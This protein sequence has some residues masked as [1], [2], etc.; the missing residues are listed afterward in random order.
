MMAD[1]ALRFEPP[2]VAFVD[3]TKGFGFLNPAHLRKSIKRTKVS[4]DDSPSLIQRTRTPTSNHGNVDNGTSSPTRFGTTLLRRALSTTTRRSHSGNDTSTTTT[5]AAANRARDRYQ[6]KQKHRSSMVDDGGV[7]HDT[8]S[9]K[10][11]P[12]PPRPQS[13]LLMSSHQHQHQQRQVALAQ[14][15]MEE[16]EVLRR[17]A[18]AVIDRHVG[19]YM[20]VGDLVSLFSGKRSGSLWDKVKLHFR[21]SNNLGRSAS[22]SNEHAHQ[23]RVFG[24]PLDNVDWGMANND[25]GNDTTTRGD[26]IGYMMTHHP[27]M[28]ACFSKSAAIPPIMQ[29]CIL[30]LLQ[31]DLTVEGIFRKNGNIRDLRDMCNKI[32]HDE[33][34]IQR[35]FHDTSAIQLAA[36]LKRYLRDLPEPLLTYKLH[37]LFVASLRMPTEKETKTVLHL[38]CCMLPK[39]NRDLLQLLCLFWN[40]VASLHSK[41]KMTAQNLALVLTPSLLVAPPSATTSPHQSIAAAAGLQE[42]EVVRLLIQYQPEFITI[43]SELLLS[44]LLQEDVGSPPSPTTRSYASLLRKRTMSA[45]TLASFIDPQ[46]AR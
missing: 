33:P 15:S 8:T 30:A 34:Y 40:Q 44:P 26:A 41:N 3:T 22:L 2:A 32:D 18:A 42:I 36:I 13:T 5:A 6:R 45:I 4:S 21:N 25:G 39:P 37:S 17:T 1:H 46:S 10:E 43:P 38:A 31:Q 24:Q 29:N 14:V 19:Q 11:S 16:D 12:I 23:R 28:A 9:I 35:L 7:M 27:I 20:R